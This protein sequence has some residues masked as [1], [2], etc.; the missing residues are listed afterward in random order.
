MNSSAA[1]LEI[2]SIGGW[3]RQ[4]W[5]ALRADMTGAMSYAGIFM[6]I[7]MS[8]QYGLVSQGYGLFYF[9][10]ATG[11]I[12]FLPVLSLA[13]YGV[14]PELR[15]GCRVGLKGLMASFRGCPAAVWAI[16]L[17]TLAIYLIWVTDA[18]IIYS[19]YFDFEPMPGLLRDP[20][21]RDA[22]FT[23]VL[24]AHLLFAILGLITFFVGGFSVPHARVQ[25][26]GL[27]DAV[28]YSS[29]GVAG[30]FPVMICW[31]LLSAGMLQLVL[32]FAL[33]LL[34]FAL[35]LIAY[36]NLACYEQLAGIEEE[37]SPTDSP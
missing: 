23:F 8:L 10:L 24:Y 16:A 31:A 32:Q 35:P 4:G 15:Q 20:Q 3:L 12:L 11:F 28:V 5:R 14:M 27:V 36:G 19:I 17:F 30:N 18:L 22:A 26:A 34:I 13:Y 37:K 21:S 7:G 1:R 29:K 9:I 6:I 25:Q 33:P 2:G